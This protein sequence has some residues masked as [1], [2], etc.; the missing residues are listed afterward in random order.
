M[1]L[2]EY[3]ALTGLVIPTSRQARVTAE[4]RHTQRILEGLLG[5]SLSEDL[6]D[7]NQYTEIGKTTYECPCP[8]D[9]LTTTAP[10]AVV[11][12]YRLFSY[13]EK[14]VFL[15]ID[16][17]TA[18]HKVKL[19]K[20][21]ITYR[22]L[23]TDEYRLQWKRGL[24]KYLEQIKCWCSCCD[25]CSQ[26][27]LAVDADWVWSDDAN[28]PEEL[29]DVWCEMIT[30]YADARRNIKSETLGPHSYTKDDMTP[31]E[32]LDHNLFVIKRYAGPNG[33]IKRTLTV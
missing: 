21:G 25:G 2:L 24:V 5:Y 33:S 22:T 13:N 20:D 11:L 3:Q 19:V 28:I 16:P 29:K 6:Y 9:T 7:E 12:A 10:D 4:I 23:D 32:Q 30:W 17:C 27:Q 14:D 8:S 15:S 1:T 18:V 26:M 31:P